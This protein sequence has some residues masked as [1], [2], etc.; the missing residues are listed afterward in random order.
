MSFGFGLD[1]AGYSTGKSEVAVAQFENGTL[2]ITLLGQSPFSRKTKSS[3][4][5]DYLGK[6]EAAEIDAMLKIGN[7]AVDVPIDLQGLPHTPA[8]P[9][10]WGQT[11]R[12]IDFA[13]GALAPF[14]DR[15]GSVVSRF[16]NALRFTAASELL[17]K[18]LFETYPSGNL[19]ALG[20]L[21]KGYKGAQQHVN[22][23]QIATF[24]GLSLSGMSDDELDAAICAVTAVAPAEFI[25]EK[26]DLS[27]YLFNKTGTEYVDIPRG[28]RLLRTFL[29]NKTEVI[30]SSYDQWMSGEVS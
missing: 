3:N 16:Q 12:P 26:S 13:L 18:K 30:R 9:F 15:L 20:S 23:D 11:K 25:L 28:Y 24:L 1:L 21:A 17:G 2:Q 6:L 8:S 4:N 27:E 19:A 29:S 14:A 5:N 10:V 7:L 22:R